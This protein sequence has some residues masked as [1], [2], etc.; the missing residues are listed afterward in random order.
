MSEAGFLVVVVF[1]FFLTPFLCYEIL[2]AAE[3]RTNVVETNR[4]TCLRAFPDDAGLFLQ[5]YLKSFYYFLRSQI[6]Q[7]ASQIA[8]LRVLVIQVDS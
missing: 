2:A 1:W 5:S 4:C 6:D 3:L 8:A 7:K